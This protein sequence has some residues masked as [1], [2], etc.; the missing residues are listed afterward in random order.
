MHR[1]RKCEEKEG[2]SQY[3]NR[4]EMSICQNKLKSQKKKKINSH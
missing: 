3:K 4:N 2:T 1:R